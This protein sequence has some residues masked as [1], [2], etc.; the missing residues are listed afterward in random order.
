MSATVLKCQL[1]IRGMRAFDF[2][3]DGSLGQFAR[4]EVCSEGRRVS[5]VVGV[6]STAVVCSVL[7]GE[8]ARRIRDV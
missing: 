7:R 8:G 4:E 3:R 1:R 2:E 6:A 5:L